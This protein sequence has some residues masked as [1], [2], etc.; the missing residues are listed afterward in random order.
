MLQGDLYLAKD[1]ELGIMNKKSRK[2]LDKINNTKMVDYA[3]RAKYFKK[4]LGTTGENININ[5]P[6]YCDYGA[7]IHIGENFYANFNTVMLDVAEIIIG[8]DVMFGPNVSIYTAGHP[9]DHEIR[10]TGLE[11]GKKITIGNNVWVG[12]NVVINP[13][14]N[15]GNNVVIA[16]GAV[17]TKSF[18]DNLIIGGN[19]AKIIR[20]IN[21]KDKTYWETEKNKYYETIKK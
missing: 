14:I 4:L 18:A 20:E 15:I 8:D 3:K 11:F 17:V 2:L 1:F 19:P 10:N 6:F 16:S 21:E 12:G 7:N 9:I 13:G 5:K